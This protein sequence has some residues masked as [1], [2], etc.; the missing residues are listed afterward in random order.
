[1]YMNSSMKTCATNGTTSAA[2]HMSG[3]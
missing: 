3:V 1:V 2:P